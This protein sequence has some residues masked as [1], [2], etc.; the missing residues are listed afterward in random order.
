MKF[1]Y[2]VCCIRSGVFRY[3]LFMVLHMCRMCQ[4]GSHAVF[5][6]YRYTYATP[7]SITSQYGRTIIPLSV[8]CGMIMLIMYSMVW[9]WSVSKA[10]PMLIYLPKLLYP[11][12]SY[13]FLFLFFLSIGWYC[14]AWIFLLIECR[15]LSLSLAL[16]TSFRKFF[17][18]YISMTCIDPQTR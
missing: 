12:L 1:L 18:L 16:P 8:P 2:C 6:F 5:W 10:G 7:R 9:D 17:L 15:S 14:G 3:T 13:I 4:C 11:Y